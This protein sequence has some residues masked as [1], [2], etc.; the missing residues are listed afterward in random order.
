MNKQTKVPNDATGTIKTVIAEKSNTQLLQAAVIGLSLASFFTTAQGMNAYIFRNSLIA[1]LTSGAIQGILLALSMNLPKYLYRSRKNL[2][3]FFCIL[4]FTLVPLFCSS[5]FS[6]VYIADVVHGK[7]WATDSE[8]LVQ[9]AYRQELYDAKDYAHAY[10]SYLEEGMG[11]KI[12]QLEE[13]ARSLEDYQISLDLNWDEERTTYETTESGVYMSTVIDAMEQAMQ[14]SASQ[15]DRELAANTIADTK[16]SIE[17]DKALIDEELIGLNSQI[18]S[19]NAQITTI[20]NQ[21]SRAV[22]GNDITT[23]SNNLRIYTNLQ[24][25]AATRQEQLHSQKSDLESAL[26]RLTVYETRLNQINS[27]SSISIR[28][29]LLAMQTEFFS[30]TPDDEKLLETASAIFTSLRNAA[31]DVAEN[32]GGGQ[33]TFSYSSL[34]I[35]MNQ[36]ISNLK[37]Y[38]DI[39]KIEASLDDLILELRGETDTP[40]DSAAT[41]PSPAPTLPPDQQNAPEKNG[42]DTPDVGGETTTLDAPS[43]T[44]STNIDAA[45]QTDT[46]DNLE[47]QDQNPETAEDEQKQEEKDK[48]TETSEEWK[49]IWMERLQKLKSQISAMP[50]YL[51]AQVSDQDSAVQTGVLTNSQLS[52]LSQ[53]DRSTSSDHLDKVIRLYIADHSALYQGV[54]Y[55]LSPNRELAIFSGILALFLDLAGFVFGFVDLNRAVPTGEGENILTDSNNSTSHNVREQNVGSLHINEKSAPSEPPFQ[56]KNFKSH[57]AGQKEGP[58]EPGWSIL[59]SQNHYIVLTGD[60]ERKDGIYFYQVFQNG[61]LQTWE[62]DDDKPYDMGIWIQSADSRTKGTAV[63]PEEKEICFSYQGA[64]AQD[65]IYLNGFLSYD[66]GSLILITEHKEGDGVK[67]DYR[68][69][70][71]VEEYVPVHSYHPKNGENQT[72]PAKDLSENACYTEISVLALNPKGT[73][74]V[75]IYAIAH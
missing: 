24:S 16:S 22:A 66:E 50:V 15:Q 29:N 28:S 12:L 20:N 6:Y 68:Y 39:K 33:N 67:K 74:I 34:L 55:L 57:T 25:S 31:S 2:L 8:L 60:Y 30:E 7:S 40:A 46:G 10:R 47:F 58:L 62:V 11:E 54:I 38:S 32:T 21:I 42:T 51:S 52:V 14:P 36:L 41:A 61:I 65:G 56:T 45:S 75:A 43:E 1:Y 72:F 18:E 70:A 13:Q 37:E 59:E 48:E 63:S 44:V 35:Q 3:I 64:P 17:A 26:R 4:L 73:R 9:Q 19:W 69:L 53:F 23:L 27:T 49:T 71:N 5:W